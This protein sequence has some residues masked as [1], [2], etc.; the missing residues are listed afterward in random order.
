MDLIA[1]RALPA[2]R[3]SLTVSMVGLAGVAAFVVALLPLAPGVSLIL[4]WL[5][6][7][8][9][10]VALAWR[11]GGGRPLIWI[12]T[13]SHVVRT[14]LAVLLVEISTRG[15]RLFPS[16]Q[17]GDGFWAFAPD[18]AYYHHYATQAAIAVRAGLGLPYFAGGSEYPILLAVIYRWFGPHPL[19][20]ALVN[21]WI[22]GCAML[23]AFALARGL[24]GARAGHVA[25][26][27]VGFWP[28]LALWSTQLL[29]DCIILAL[30]FVFLLAVER[31]YR[32]SGVAL[33]GPI[34]LTALTLMLLDRLRLFVAVCLFVAA[35][36]IGI[37]KATV[38]LARRER[39]GA[40]GEGALIVI[41]T[42]AM[43]AG[44]AIKPPS[45]ADPFSYDEYLQLAELKLSQGDHAGALE[46]LRIV[47]RVK[48]HDKPME[49]ADLDRLVQAEL[50]QLKLKLKTERRVEGSAWRAMIQLE[51]PTGLW[52]NLLR[53][54]T[55]QNLRKGFLSYKAGSQVDTDVRLTSPWAVVRYLPKAILNATLT[56]NPFL[57]FAAVGSTGELRG[58]SMLEIP[59][60]ALL[61]ICA[62]LGA[63]RA[64]AAAPELTTLLG[65]YALLLAAFLGLAIPTIGVVFRL[66]LDF[67][68]PLGIL[69]GVWLE[70]T[71]GRRRA[72]AGA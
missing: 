70:G 11:A 37:V 2:R 48:Y 61:L 56:P 27:L 64:F 13:A 36:M 17:L 33:V 35:V 3:R 38:H 26:G 62:I 31:F 50:A 19:F 22:V 30:I 24:G 12:V 54:R 14:G 8:G 1:T 4:F 52:G 46:Q 20:G 69:A 39:G 40:L 65:L 57:R 21:S 23:L 18:S 44:V 41:L 10:L 25:A 15:L 28:S 34:A 45:S 53:F 71:G 32:R 72:P 29:K 63:R 67:V 5:G 42:L 68:L 6:G 59:L 7:A 16:L 66:R 58:A 51:E 55:L 49:D 9:T 47:V 60:V 43:V